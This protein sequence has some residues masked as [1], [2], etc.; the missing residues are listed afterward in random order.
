LKKLANAPSPP[1]RA[2]AAAPTETAAKTA[3]PT[4]TAA[5]AAA[6]SEEAKAES[7]FENKVPSQVGIE[8]SKESE[9]DPMADTIASINDF[10][11]TEKD[12]VAYEKGKE[13]FTLLKDSPE[14]YQKLTNHENQGF[15]DLGNQFSAKFRKLHAD[16]NPPLNEVAQEVS[17][18]LKADIKANMDA[19]NNF[20]GNKNMPASTQK[21]NDY[22]DKILEMLDENPSYRK[23]FT[24]T[25]PSFVR[26]V[27]EVRKELKIE[28][29]VKNF[30]S[31]V[32]N[33][34][35]FAV[36][37]GLLKNLFSEIK[38]GDLGKA[39]SLMWNL[40]PR[41][42]SDLFQ[43]NLDPKLNIELSKVCLEVLYASYKEGKYTQLYL[44]DMYTILNHLPRSE[45]K[46]FLNTHPGLGISLPPTAEQF[47]FNICETAIKDFSSSLQALKDEYN[48]NTNLKFEGA[49]TPQ[50]CV[51]LFKRMSLAAHPDKGGSES[52]MKDLN[53]LYEQFATKMCAGLNIQTTSGSDAIREMGNNMEAFAELKKKAEEA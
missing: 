45:Q 6:P 16:Y 25:Y 11:K 26:N 15:K 29:E 12:E 33:N 30:L 19:F 40:Y 46:A 35:Y 31:S 23:E 9:K 53:N 51:A 41:T 32:N 24:A 4:E 42:M 28:T 34:P 13:I 48:L 5:K 49:S 17:K 1:P 39:Y 8:T 20:F 7:E 22:A 27:R 47:R 18:E 43:F 3:A 52:A 2:K 36:R 14:I 38:D 21:A 50:E 10:L 44:R 37:Q